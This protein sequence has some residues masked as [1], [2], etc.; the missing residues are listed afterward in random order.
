MMAGGQC[1]LEALWL[2]LGYWALGTH[3]WEDTSCVSSQLVTQQEQALVSVARFNTEPRKSNPKAVR[4][5]RWSTLGFSTTILVLWS[6][7][8][9]L[10]SSA[11]ATLVEVR[12]LQLS[13]A[14][15]TPM[16]YCLQLELQLGANLL[17]C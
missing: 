9:M 3:V 7:V 15:C 6:T 14:S 8:T 2:A 1:P 17:K 13:S 10:M 12:V 11:E 5:L 16:C 4:R